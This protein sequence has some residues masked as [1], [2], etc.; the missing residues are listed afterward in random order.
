LSHSSMYSMPPA[1]CCA[2]STDI[3]THLWPNEQR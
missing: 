3:V 1:Q 2:G